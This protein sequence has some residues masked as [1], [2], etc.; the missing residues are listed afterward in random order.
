MITVRVKELPLDDRPREKLLLRGAQNL[1]DAELL[2]ILLRTGKKGKSV[3]QL[4]QELITVS[5]NLSQ[6]ATK[7]SGALEKFDGIG[8]DKAATL[9]AAFELSRRITMQARW[10]SE[11]SITS[12]EDVAIL[13]SPLLRDENREHFLIVCLNTANKI[14]RYEVLS[15]GNLDTSIVHPR[16]VFR[17]AIDNNAKSIIL[18]HNHP[19][20]NAEASKA[21]IAVTKRLVEAGKILDIKIFDH[22]II[23]GE[24]YLSFVEQRY[25]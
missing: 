15:I 12:P 13:F 1:S 19:S 9:L 11:K 6:L 18:V 4:A 24:K 16:E 10:F 25:I 22:I 3:I 17:I 20:G 7:S 5:G 14:I 23:A 8:K 21:D 2:A